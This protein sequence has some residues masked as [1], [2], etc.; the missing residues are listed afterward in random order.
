M[1]QFTAVRFVCFDAMSSPAVLEQGRTGTDNAMTIYIH[2]QIYFWSYIFKNM[3][4]CN[5][6]I[7]TKRQISLL[8][9][10]NLFLVIHFQEHAR[11]QFTHDD[12]NANFIATIP[13]Y[14]TVIVNWYGELTN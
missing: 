14:G 10:G 3:P 7:M 2:E 8:P 4:G 13:D 5:L 11:I 12:K 1:Q 9:W 6:L